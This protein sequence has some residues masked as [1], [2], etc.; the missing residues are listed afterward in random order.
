MTKT[1]R[2]VFYFIKLILLL[3]LSHAFAEDR[4]AID[5][6]LTIS[7]QDMALGN[8]SAPNTVIEYISPSCF[9]CAD[10][11]LKAFPE[12]KK[13]YIDTGKVK[14]ATRIYINDAPSL[15][16][17]ILSKC[18]ASSERFY[19]LLELYLANQASWTSSNSNVVIE[20]IFL[21]AGNSKKIF[22]E[23]LSNKNLENEII[24]IRKDAAT[25]L[26]LLGTP[27]FFVNGKQENIISASQF[28]TLINKSSR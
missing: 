1:N 20:N 17:A 10:F 19:K 2:T 3:P 24:D 23:C 4:L 5:N 22:N 13:N 11:H 8:S 7:K 14:W 15:S 21:L 25:T 9:H 18:N 27:A 26:K 6:L 16:I 28:A 12:I